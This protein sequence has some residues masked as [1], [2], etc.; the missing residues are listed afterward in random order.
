MAQNKVTSGDNIMWI[1]D[2]VGEYL[3][4]VESS[5]SYS[6]TENNQ[7]S[8]HKTGKWDSAQSDRQAALVV[9]EWRD[10]KW[11]V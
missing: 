3:L 1:L 7:I 11:Q 6:N 8:D 5:D 10:V 2:Y 9:I 4:E